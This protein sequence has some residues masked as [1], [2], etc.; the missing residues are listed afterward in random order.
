MAAKKTT[1][2]KAASKKPAADKQT[3]GIKLLSSTNK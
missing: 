1:A 3:A 2:S